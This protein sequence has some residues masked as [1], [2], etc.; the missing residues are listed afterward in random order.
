M[1]GSRFTRDFG[2]SAPDTWAATIRSLRDVELRRGL[3]NLLAAGSGSPPT[4]PQFRKACKQA[5]ESGGMDRNH[6]PQK[7]LPK[8]EYGEPVHAHAQR[9]LFAYLWDK[10]GASDVALKAMIDAKN[11]IVLQFR[12]ILADDP[13]LT[14]TDIKTALFKAWNPLWKARTAAELERD[15]EHFRRTGFAAPNPHSG[16]DTQDAFA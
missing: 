2:D 10:G 3:E 5:D 16:D 14:G 13:A 4:L 11:R 9:C 6:S 7:S 8:P 12:D 15:L 1:Y